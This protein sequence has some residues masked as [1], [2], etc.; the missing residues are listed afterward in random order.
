ML[1]YHTSAAVVRCLGAMKC[2]E[3]LVSIRNHQKYSTDAR[4]AA[5]AALGAWLLQP[6]PRQLIVG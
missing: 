1:N 3:R 4:A 6:L 2:A 5:A